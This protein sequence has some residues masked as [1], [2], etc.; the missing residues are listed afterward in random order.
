MSSE[1]AVLGLGV[2]APPGKL[3][4]DVAAALAQARSCGS[5]REH[6]WLRRIY[7]ASG[8]RERASVLL[9]PDGET[10]PLETFYPLPAAPNDRGPT[11]ATRLA[12]YATEAGALAARASSTA[13]SDA[14][15]APDAVTHLITVSC[16]GVFS[17]GLDA[18]LIARLG[19]S[20]GVGRLNVRFMGCHGALNA[21][22]AAE[23][24]T[25]A[26]ADARVLVC[27][28]ELCSLHFQYASSPQQIVANALFADGAGAA[29]IGGRGKSGLRLRGTV[30]R[31]A[32]DSNAAMTWHIGDN[33]FEM[34]LSSEVPDLIRS[35]LP[36]WLDGWLANEGLDRSDIVHWAIHPG[37]PK[38]VQAVVESLGL[39][40]DASAASLAV[41]A[42]C[43]NMSSPTLLFILERLRRSGAQGSCVA[44]GFGPG[45][46]FE[47]ALL[48]F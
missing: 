1:A 17:P 5:D 40:A 8:V 3:A 33:G 48:D 43:G 18:E 22:R 16:T 34:G 13:L 2:A 6:R 47:A 30:S 21:L 41:L 7:R 29:V 36:V 32:P 23:A 46:A 26:D 4:Q 27:C 38:I 28:V 9:G 14:A 12:R 25:S 15:L 31:I 24:F 19:L 45:L 39:P 11:T 35:A 37:G 20:P 42:D 10:A 44:L